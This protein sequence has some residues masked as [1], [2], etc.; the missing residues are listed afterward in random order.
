MTFVTEAQ[1][2]PLGQGGFAW[3]C[4][5]SFY[6]DF[7]MGGDQATAPATSVGTAVFSSYSGA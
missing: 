4:A 7:V 3:S 1:N 5:E 2:R 6:G